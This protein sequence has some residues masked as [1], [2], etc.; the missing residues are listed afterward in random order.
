MPTDQRTIPV[1]SAVTSI[2]IPQRPTTRLAKPYHYRRNGIYYLRLRETGSL[3]RTV[4]VSLKT[5]DRKAAMDASRHLSETIRA[6]HLD[7]P[8]AT[9]HQLRE[10]LIWIAEGLLSSAHDVYSLRMWGD[11]YEDVAMNLTEIA[12]TMP[13]SV[14]QHEHVTDGAYGFD[15]AAFLRYVDS[16]KAE[17][18]DKLAQL[19]YRPA[20]EWVNQQAIPM[21]L[22]GSYARGLVYHSLRHS[23]SSLM[24]AHGV[25]T[26][27]A[28]AVMGHVTGTITFDTY[29]STY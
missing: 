22:E 28:Q 12:A 15:L 10:H 19:G 16:C 11:L 8:D 9:W 17:G 1:T 23:L 14:D 24:Q 2:A 6:F 25:P 20:G 13:L 3:T 29:G 27:H 18:K 26:T 21:A 4:S 5:T 7:N